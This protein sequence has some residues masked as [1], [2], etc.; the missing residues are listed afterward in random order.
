MQ[1]LQNII[2]KTVTGLVMF[3]I[4][5]K[6]GLFLIE[7]D[8]MDLVSYL[9]HDKSFLNLHK[10]IRVGDCLCGLAAKPARSSYRKTA[11][12]IKDTPFHIQG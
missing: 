1:E 8:R 10:S 5:E 4:E 6:G 3:N 2:L 11:I 12:R 9:A 7:D